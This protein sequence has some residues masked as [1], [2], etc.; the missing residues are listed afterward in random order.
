[1][2]LSNKAECISDRTALVDSLRNQILSIS[3]DLPIYIPLQGAYTGNIEEKS[4]DLQFKIREFLASLED[5][6]HDSKVML[7]LGDAGSGKSVFVRQLFRQL[8]KEFK[9]GNSIPLW[10]SLP[11]LDSPFERA[12]EEVLEKQGLSDEQI[13]TLKMNEAFLF[14][15]DGYDELHNFQNCYDA[16]HWSQWRA[17]VLITCRTQALYYQR[18]YDRYFIPFEGSQSQSWLLS[19]LYI[20][21]F[22]RDQISNYLLQYQALNPDQKVTQEQLDKIPNLNELI[23]SPFM[24]HMAVECLSEILS[25]PRDEKMLHVN[26]YDRYVEHWF[27]R[28]AN[29]VTV[30]NS[31]QDSE[32]SLIK[33]FWK[34]CKALAVEMHA[35]NVKVIPYCQRSG[36]RYGVK[37]AASVWDSYFTP[38]TVLERSACPLKS[39]GNNYY[40]F[41]HATL[42][43]YFATRTIYD[44]TVREEKSE[45]K[46]NDVKYKGKEKDELQRMF[47]P[48]SQFQHPIHRSLFTQDPESIQM[49]SERIQ[50]D[51]K[52]KRQ[53][54]WCVESSKEHNDFAIAAANAITALMRAGVS[55]NGADLRGI[56]VSGAD[57]SGGYFDRA[58][59]SHADLQGCQLNRVW[60]RNARLANC[61]L[62]KANF[63]EYPYFTHPAFVRSIDYR[64]ELN[65]LVTASGNNIYIWEI[66]SGKCTQELK[67][68]KGE[69]TSVSL[70][71]DGTKVASGSWDTTVRVW[72][73]RSGDA[74]VLKGHDSVI[75]SVRLSSDGEKVV[76]GSWDTIIRVWTV[77]S[78]ESVA[79]YGHQDIVRCVQLSR[80]GNTVVSGSYD[81]TVRVWDV[82]NG[83]SR[84][85]Q[86]HERCV[87]CVDL[88][89]DEQMVASG[90]WDTM[91][92]LWNRSSGQSMALTGHDGTIKSVKL[93]RDGRTVASGGDDK[94]VRV[95]DVKSGQSIVLRG[96]DD[97]VEIVLLSNDG[98]TVASGSVDKRVRIWDVRSGQSVVLRWHSQSIEGVHLSVD[99]KTIVSG[100]RDKTV[101]VWDIENGKSQVL[102]GHSESVEGVCLDKDGWTVCS[103]SWDMSVRLWD[104]RNDTSIVLLGHEDVITSVH[105]SEN[106]TKVA[107]GSWDKTVRV[108]DVSSGESVVLRGHDRNVESVHMSPNGFVVATGSRDST[109][110]I[111]D[112]KSGQAE[113]LRG[114]EEGV[115]C[116][117][118]SHDGK[119]VASASD[120]KT[121]RVWDIQT[122]SAVIL[123]GHK[124]WVRGVYLSNDGQ[125]VYSASLDRTVR[126]WA[127]ALRR[128]MGLISFNSQV[129]AFS[130]QDTP[131]QFVVGLEDGSVQLWHRLDARGEEWQLMWSSNI[132]NP[133]LH[134]DRCE[135]TGALGLSQENERLLLQ[136]EACNLEKPQSTLQAMTE[137]SHQLFEIKSP[138]SLERSLVLNSEI[139]HDEPELKVL[140][141][142]DEASCFKKIGKF[143]Q[144]KK[145]DRKDD[146]SKNGQNIS[147]KDKTRKHKLYGSSLEEKHQ[148]YYDDEDP[149]N[150]LTNGK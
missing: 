86:E 108:W 149:S 58:D 106:G 55:F 14:I 139:Q 148:K 88:S 69:V 130:V 138:D 2:D 144:R 10:I 30:A 137:T 48:R 57:L 82:K 34:Y 113:I 54:L 90:G 127:L 40:G 134:V 37:Q 50:Q 98:K 107:S 16:N 96:H 131:G 47:L 42:V 12:V 43:N 15:V 136:R 27:A 104:L 92:R 64:P 39:Y 28:E 4:F 7:L 105:M 146:G 80:D 23:T 46:V 114:H 41:I 72:D 31:E 95:W 126:I 120:D 45:E 79:L 51:E 18:D 56:R 119:T 132:L 94:S 19:K 99:G 77:S 83:E 44:L 117:Y 111:W 13:A 89:D 129:R 38:E 110:R 26:L 87:E 101:Q 60:L 143:F 145:S 84:V 147:A 142:T 150:S 9:T 61:Q 71:I 112:V 75:E 65:L 123:Q 81:R 128:E 68:H 76:S 53:M 17:K 36:I 6:Y 32:E 20:A 124:N 125:T 102:R 21:P 11:E 66:E 70:N 52:F 133:S 63:G 5:N 135:F 91:V 118:L 35:Q 22:N 1:M 73:L 8:W 97:T 116:V 74:V 100:S 121:V 109:V 122:H 29:K 67:G 49:L 93:G 33:R 103:G 85:I 115:N 62:V 24:L 141:T 78:G 3:P 25:A 140:E 59:L